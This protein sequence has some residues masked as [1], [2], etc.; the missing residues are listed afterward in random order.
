VDAKATVRALMDAIQQGDFEKAKTFLSKN[1]QFSGSAPE[2]VGGDAWLAMNRR[3]KKAF[4]NLDYHFQLVNMYADTARI[5]TQ[6]RGTQTG[7]LDLTDRNMGRHR[8][9][10]RSFVS[11]R[12]DGKV[13]V[14]EGRV[15]SWVVQ[16]AVG[17]GMKAILMQLGIT[18]PTK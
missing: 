7:T 15:T 11:P 3:M 12:E 4:P 14:E 8:G 10:T 17:A 9:S 6:L 18:P 5:S 2:P 16:P 13:T 1:F